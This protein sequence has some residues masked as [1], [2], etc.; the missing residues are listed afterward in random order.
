MTAT[1]NGR[2]A[3]QRGMTMMEV[4]IAILILSV[5][6]FSMLGLLMNSMKLTA[7]SNYRAMATQHAHAMANLVSSGGSAVFAYDQSQYKTPTSD[8]TCFAAGC[9]QT[10]LV[11]TQVRIWLD[12][13]AVALPK[14]A[15]VIC[16]S[17]KLAG[18]PDD[19]KC[20]GDGTNPYVVK[21]CWDETRVGVGKAGAGG[22]PYYECIYTSQ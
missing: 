12:Q 5:G 3:R 6:L 14:G 8:D 18:N 10:D 2:A 19:W 13:I 20:D 9:S 21:V 1:M 4:L 11:S 16:R 15:G 17:T 22:T 7:T